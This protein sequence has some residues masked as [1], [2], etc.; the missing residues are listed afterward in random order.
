LDTKDKDIKAL[1]AD[2]KALTNFKYLLESQIEDMQQE[3]VPVNEC[4]QSLNQQIIDLKCN[5]EAQRNEMT[6]KDLQLDQRDMKLRSQTKNVKSLEQTIRL[7]KREFI[8]LSGLIDSDD[9]ANRKLLKDR[10]NMAY[11][12]YRISEN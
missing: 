4:I 7:L 12:K 2:K 9:T 8:I 10:L 6:K 1:Q 5:L 3:K 11:Q